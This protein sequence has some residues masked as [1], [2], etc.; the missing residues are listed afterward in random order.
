[1]VIL[2]I[3]GNATEHLTA[4]V[5]A[6]KNK[7]DLSLGVAVGSSIQIAVFVV[8]VVVLVGWL[9]GH[10]FLLTFDMFQVVVLTISVI[11]ANFAIADGSSH[12]LMGVQLISTYV[13]VAMGFFFYG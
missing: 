1:M 10:K 13:L 8:P 7:M 6:Y 4:V 5:V 2:P 9:T 11:H 12:W 3:A